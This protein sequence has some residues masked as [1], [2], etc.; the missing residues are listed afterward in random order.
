VVFDAVAG[1]TYHVV[2]AG[3]ESERGLFTLRWRRIVRPSND[4][5]AAAQT[6]AGATGTIDGTTLGAGLEPGEPSHGRGAAG[7]VWY[8]WTSPATAPVTF[9]TC[10]S[11]IDTLHAIYTGDALVPLAPVVQ[12]D[13]VCSVQSRVRLAA[14]AG[15]TYRIA[16]A[17]F[18]L[19]DGGAFT[20][21]WLRPPANDDRPNSLQL[22]GTSGTYSGSSD[23]ASREADEPPPLRGGSVWFRWRAP[24]SASVA[25][26][27]CTSA[28][29]TILA[30]Y[31]DR[32]VGLRIAAS[33]D[34]ACPSGDGSLVVLHP[35]PGATY[36]VAVDG[37]RA[38]TGTF[39]LAW[40][41]PPP[42]AWCRVPDV[43]GQKLVAARTL[44]RNAN[45]SVG[46]ELRTHSALVPRGVVLA[47]RPAASSTRQNFGTPVDIEVSTGPE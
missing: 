27:T 34:D 9:Q 28:F 22:S 18:G 17:D 20:L 33:N 35:R 15:T 32:P 36:V 4:D 31:R 47:Q 14:Q 39:T 1:T 46:L 13:D 29:D 7:S 23:G 8:A 24:T 6:L 38:A 43:R 37:V 45:C 16:V 41:K 12:N 26:S 3:Y 30:A 40:G 42:Y 11:Q 10:G 5:F 2:V 25:F 44:I 19:Q 21:A